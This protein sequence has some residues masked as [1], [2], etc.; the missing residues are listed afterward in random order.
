MIPAVINDRC[1]LQNIGQPPISF[2]T[3]GQIL[4]IGQGIRPGSSLAVISLLPCQASI[5]I[6]NRIIRW[7]LLATPN[8]TN[9]ITTGFIDRGAATIAELDIPC[10]FWTARVVTP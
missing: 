6:N 5:L 1:Q 7:G 8:T 2:G 9:E 3:K 4:T 10:I